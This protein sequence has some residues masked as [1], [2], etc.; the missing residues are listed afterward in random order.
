VNTSAHNNIS[1]YKDAHKNR[2]KRA[3]GQIDYTQQTE[4]QKDTVTAS[5]AETETETETVTKTHKLFDKIDDYVE[6]AV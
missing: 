6:K 4:T 5:E 1:T 2:H 3:K